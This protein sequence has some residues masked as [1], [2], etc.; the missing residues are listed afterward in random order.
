MSDLDFDQFS[1]K[2]VI[3]PDDEESDNECESTAGTKW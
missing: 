2:R 3:S 1:L